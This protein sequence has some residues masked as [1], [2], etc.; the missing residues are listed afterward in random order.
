MRLA[1]KGSVEQAIAEMHDARAKGELD[2]G[3]QAG[4]DALRALFRANHVWTRRTTCRELS[5]KRPTA[6]TM[7]VPPPRFIALARCNMHL[8]M[9]VLCMCMHEKQP[10]IDSRGGVL[11]PPRRSSLCAGG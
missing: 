8:H 7:E 9:H 1:Y 6:K 4:R 10:K 2:G 3:T 11:V 5:R